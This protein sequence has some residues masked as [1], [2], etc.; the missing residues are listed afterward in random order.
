MLDHVTHIAEYSVMF[1]GYLD[2]LHVGK[3]NIFFSYTYENHV[4]SEY[5]IY[6]ITRKI[7]WEGMCDKGFSESLK[8]IFGWVFLQDDGYIWDIVYDLR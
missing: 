2:P 4:F 6:D 3:W 1:V 5:D 8:N 7:I